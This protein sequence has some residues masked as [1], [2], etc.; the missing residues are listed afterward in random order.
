[1]VTYFC[2]RLVTKINVMNR[3]KTSRNREDTKQ[4][5]LDAVDEIVKEDGFEKLGVNLVAS[6]ADVSK[7]L[8]YRYFGSLDGLIYE[9]VSKY[10]FWAN[11]EE[12]P[13]DKRDMPTFVKNLFKMQIKSIRD[14]YVL[15]RIYR[16]EFMSDNQFVIELRKKREETGIRLVKKIGRLAHV[17]KKE[18]AVLATLISSSITYLALLSDSFGNYNGI[19][20]RTN[21]GWKQIERVI[22]NFVD[23]YFNSIKK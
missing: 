18:I 14:N 19:D 11:M 4:S 9:Y 12:L 10:D 6:R 16:W 21:A 8:I 3:E 5:L 22:D 20:I 13:L 15:R 17:S 7:M 2:D 23:V 1:M